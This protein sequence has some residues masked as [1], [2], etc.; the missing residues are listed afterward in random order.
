MTL[1]F[2][3]SASSEFLDM[4]WTVFF[5]ER[6]RGLTLGVHFPWLADPGGAHAWLA[7]IHDDRPQ[8]LAGL[9][10]KRHF[11]RLDTASIGLVCVRADK[12][13]QGL[14][15]SLLSGAVAGANAL[16]MTCLTLWTGKPSVY[17]KHGFEIWD[18]S[19]FGW[20]RTTVERAPSTMGLPRRLSW[21]DAEERNTRNRGLP[22]FSVGGYRLIDAFDRGHAVVVVDVDGPIVAEWDGDVVAV[23]QMLRAA[24]PATWRLN[25]LHNDPLIAALQT[26]GVDVDLRESQLQMW[27]ADTGAARTNLPRL[28]ILDRI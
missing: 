19:V 16:G 20:V 1:T 2:E 27:R 9:V 15:Q 4:V 21:P 3:P 12:R 26:S 11:N 24:L 23:A 6:G 17:L 25:A 8:L 22:P 5:R 13:G 7:T 28:R 10:V 18:Q 14:S